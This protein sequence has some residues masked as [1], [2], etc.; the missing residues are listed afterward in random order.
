MHF[1]MNHRFCVN[2]M[3]FNIESEDELNTINLIATGM[4]EKANI[5][6]R[7]NPAID[8]DTHP[9][10]ATG[11]QDNKFG[12]E[13]SQVVSLYKKASQMELWFIKFETSLYEN[14]L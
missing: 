13:Q 12:I 1:N 2:I 5:S 4:G 14:I 10:I 3:C 6:I 7:V 8:V 11:M 9:Y